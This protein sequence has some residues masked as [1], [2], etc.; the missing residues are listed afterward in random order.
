[1]AIEHNPTTTALNIGQILKKNWMDLAWQSTAEWT[2]PPMTAY[3]N[4]QSLM[5][6]LKRNI[7]T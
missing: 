1:M 5:G 4:A 2:A 7:P 3:K 6:I